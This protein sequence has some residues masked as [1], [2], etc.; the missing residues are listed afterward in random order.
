MHRFKSVGGT[1]LFTK[2][3]LWYGKWPRWQ[4]FNTASILFQKVQF[5]LY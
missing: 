1:W 3:F 2:L 5:H 4:L